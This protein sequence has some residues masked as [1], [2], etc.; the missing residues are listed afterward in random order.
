MNQISWLFV[1]SIIVCNEIKKATTQVS[2][3]RGQTIIKN[4]ANTGIGIV[5]TKAVV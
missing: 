2:V 5:A 1:T 3:N 4:V